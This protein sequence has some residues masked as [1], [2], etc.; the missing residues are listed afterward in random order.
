MP[1]RSFYVRI[2]RLYFFLNFFL[3]LLF[4][5]GIFYFLLPRPRFQKIAHRLQ[6][7]WSGYLLRTAGIRWR[8]FGMENWPP[9]G[10]FV[11]VANHSSALDILLMYHCL[12]RVF[13]FVAK[14]EHAQTPLFGVMFGHTHIAVDRKNPLKAA[15]AMEKARADLERGIPIVI[16]PEGTMNTRG[17]GLLPFKSGAFR[18]AAEAG[19]PVVPVAFPDHSRLLPRIYQLFYPGGGP[20]VSNIFIGPPMYPEGN[21]NKWPAL[22]DAAQKFIHGHLENPAFPKI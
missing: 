4:F 9:Q 2:W 15:K 11:V 17:H 8:I 16:F 3:T 20:G 21:K 7:W 6:V 19:V 10:S 1:M 22:R 12:P 13:H 5:F 14:V 18:L